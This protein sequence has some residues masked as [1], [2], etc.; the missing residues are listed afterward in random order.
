MHLLLQNHHIHAPPWLLAFLRWLPNR[1]SRWEVSPPSYWELN[2]IVTSDKVTPSPTTHG[3]T[4]LP[5]LCLSCLSELQALWGEDRPFC[6]VPT[7]FPGKHSS[8]LLRVLLKQHHGSSHNRDILPSD[9]TDKAGTRI[10]PGDSHAA[11]TSWLVPVRAS[12]GLCHHTVSQVQQAW[13]QTESLFW[14]WSYSPLSGARDILNLSK[15]NF[16][17]NAALQFCI[18]FYS[19]SEKSLQKAQSPIV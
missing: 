18:T 19:K 13:E 7:T 3:P 14:P 17:I 11:P 6:Q 5:T 4:S 12:S 9:R 15:P 8:H 16:T 10:S 1:L 2:I